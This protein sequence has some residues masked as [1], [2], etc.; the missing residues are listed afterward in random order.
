MVDGGKEGKEE[1]IWSV[2]P[3]FGGEVVVPARFPFLHRLDV[4]SQLAEG[5]D[6]T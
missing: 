4:G 1:L 3:E 6:A 2:S 5:D